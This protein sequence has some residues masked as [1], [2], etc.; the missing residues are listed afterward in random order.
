[1]SAN[2][3]DP[4]ICPECGGTGMHPW[5]P[6]TECPMCHGTGGLTDAAFDTR[7]KIPVHRAAR[8]GHD[9]LFSV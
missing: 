5:K 9:N 4:V 8:V 6:R 3:Y 1:M 2:D 7:Y